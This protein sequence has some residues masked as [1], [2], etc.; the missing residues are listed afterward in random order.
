MDGHTIISQEKIRIVQDL[1][2]RF[3]GNEFNL[4]R[5]AVLG[6]QSSGKSSVLE[7]ILQLDVLP[8]GNNLVTRCPIIISLKQWH[9]QKTIL[10]GDELPSNS[11]AKAIRNK[12]IT[13]CGSSRGIVDKPIYLELYME[14]TLNLVLVDL[15][16]LTKIP[17]GDQPSDIEQQ[18]LNIAKKYIK[19]DNT[20]ILCVIPA[21]ADIA[22][23]ESLKVA[24]E[25]D[26]EYDRTIGVLT[27]IDLM[28]RGTDCSDILNN[29]HPKLKKGYIGVINRSQ[30]D[31]INNI[32]INEA[33]N[34]ETSWFSNHSVYKEYGCKIG[35]R[36]LLSQLGMIFNERLASELPG[37][38]LKISQVV[39]QMKN[40]LQKI[41]EKTD[42]KILINEFINNVGYLIGSNKET[43]QNMQANIIKKWCNE[44]LS[45]KIHVSLAKLTEKLRVADQ[46][47]LL[48][49]KAIESVIKEYSQAIS[50]LIIEC[51]SNK[52]DEILRMIE[53][54]SNS[55]NK[56]AAGVLAEK[57][58]KMLVEQFCKFKKSLEDNFELQCCAVNFN[59]PDFMKSSIIS[60]MVAERIKQNSQMWIID[61]ETDI[62]SFDEF[63]YEISSALINEYVGIVGRDLKNVTIKMIRHMFGDY[64]KDTIFA[65]LRLMEGDS[66]LKISSSEVDAECNELVNNIMILEDGLQ[67]L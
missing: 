19:Q 67:K 59:H 34:A 51:C 4:P 64:I 18:V 37:L 8:R 6:S 25:L 46:Y 44:I 39:T 23:C 12:M 66:R 43:G 32:S 7:Q 22:T 31:I 55:K 13:N 9:K 63:I 62:F 65:N 52:F 3:T 29:L 14:N 50:R 24:K 49:D 27:K 5:I 15:P 45:I 17:V 36:Y 40:K 56:A 61:T 26:N 60:K 2:G 47:L 33:L 48:P 35:S 42:S 54:C 58:C 41:R 10:D 28:D 1:A 53:E 16:G 57:M 20:I 11:I 21:N 30:Q 38:K